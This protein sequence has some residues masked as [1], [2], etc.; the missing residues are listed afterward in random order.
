MAS[1]ALRM[2]CGS[3]T[4]TGAAIDVDKIGFRPQRVEL[5]VTA[6]T[7]AGVSGF[8]QETMADAAAHK[9]LA[10][11]TG[12]QVSVNGVTPRAGGFRLGTDADLNNSGDTIHWTAY[13]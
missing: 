6:G 1:G 10:A 3:L 9:R 4:A 12:S 13:E 8:W 11:G 2:V 7:K 5:V